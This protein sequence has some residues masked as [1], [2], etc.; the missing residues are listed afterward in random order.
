MKTCKLTQPNL[1]KKKINYEK[2]IY[3]YKSYVRMTIKFDLLFILSY[4]RFILS[5][6]Q[7]DFPVSQR[8]NK[9]EMKVS[10]WIT[11]DV[12]YTNPKCNKS[13]NEKDLVNISNYG[14]KYLSLNSIPK[15]I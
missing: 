3:L 15:R 7:K 1:K 5:Y 10:I 11:L 4:R 12:A 2:K 14:Y 6:L 9:N 8:V 13:F